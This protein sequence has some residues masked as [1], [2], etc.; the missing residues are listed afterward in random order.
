[1][2]PCG[3]GLASSRFVEAA[4]EFKKAYESSNDPAFLYNMA[5]C[6]RRANNAKLALWSYEEYLKKDPDALQR[7]T[8]EARI[9]ELKTQLGGQ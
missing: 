6:Y 4:F 2:I 3:S 1:V 9:Q 8:V 5:L 7:A